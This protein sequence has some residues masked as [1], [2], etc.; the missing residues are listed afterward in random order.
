MPWT[1][2]AKI[3]GVPMPLTDAYIDIINVV[4][5]KDWRKAG[6]TAEEMG[7]AGMDKEHLLHYVTT[8]KRA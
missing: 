7:I 8:G 3:V 5:E 1:A 2:V 6:L 4:H